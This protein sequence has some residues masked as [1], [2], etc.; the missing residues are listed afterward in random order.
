MVSSSS[1]PQW[2]VVLAEVAENAELAEGSEGARSVL[3][4]MFRNEGI[5]NKRLSQV[6]GIAVPALAAVRGEMQKA[7]IL[8]DTRSLGSSGRRWAKDNLN[9]SFESEP[10]P[11]GRSISVEDIPEG[12]SKLEKVKELLEE[13]PSPDFALDQSRATYET[14]VKRTLYL[15]AKG[16]LEGRRIIFLGDDDAI[17]LAVGLTGLSAKV[18]VVDIDTRVIEFLQKSSKELGLDN[19]AVFEHDL[20]DPCPDETIGAFDVVVTDPPYTVPGMRLFLK[21][22]RQ[23]LRTHVTTRT[24]EIETVG[25]R[26]LLSFG[27][28]PPLESQLSQISILEHGFTIRE[29]VPDFNHYM[30]ARILGQFSNLY[31]LHT[32]S[33]TGREVSFE[34]RGRPLYT[35][36]AK[37]AVSEYRPVGYHIVGE[38]SG[39]ERKTILD[40]DLIREAFLESLESAKLGVVDVFQHRYDPYGYSVVAI[41]ESSHASI[42]TWPEHGYAGVDIFLCSEVEFGLNAMD[43]LK[44][45]LAPR[46]SEVRWMARGSEL[47]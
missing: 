3:V 13:R 22:A 47:E 29:M 39:V 7:G 31:Y 35:R 43:F 46:D 8:E 44:D 16:D 24:G 2:E 42:H 37:E 38:L 41:L 1:D 26:C 36:Q 27:N 4:A 34:Y 9:L 33:A 18:T 12:L 30:G 32:A 20:R 14:V 6:T 21:R 28:K 45:K 23:V 5:N 40:N 19:F 10:I 11:F 17:S 15:L 25:K